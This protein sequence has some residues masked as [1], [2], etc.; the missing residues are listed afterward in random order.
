MTRLRAVSPKRACEARSS[1]PMYASSSTIRPTRRPGGVVADEARADQRPGGVVVGPAKEGPIDDA[2]PPP[3]V[4]ARS[5][6]SGMNRPI[7]TKK[8]G[9]SVSRKS[10]ANFEPSSA[11]QN[12][13][14][15]GSSCGSTGMPGIRKNESRMIRTAPKM[16]AAWSRPEQ[17]ADDL[18]REAGLLEQRLR[19]VEALDDERERDAR[20]DEDRPEP[21]HVAV[22]ARELRPVRPEEVA[23][24]LGEVGREQEREQDRP[25]PEQP[26]DGPLREAEHEE[27]HEIQDDEQVDRP[28]PAQKCTEIHETPSDWSALAAV[29]EPAQ[30]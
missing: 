17:A 21:D 14:R 13:R 3:A 1:R 27:T 8:P 24:R 6:L 12:S 22:F 18:V 26:P 19:L 2:Q 20:G 10:S 30:G 16:S 7:R 9:M 4:E 11:P 5:M 29:P 25:D 15:N 23:E 28:D